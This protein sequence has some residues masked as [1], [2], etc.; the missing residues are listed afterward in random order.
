MQGNILRVFANFRS[1]G[2]ANIRLKQP[3]VDITI[4]K[5][6]ESALTGF[7]DTLYLIHT[8]P[9]E[10]TFLPSVGAVTM[11]TSSSKVVMHDFL[12]RTMFDMQ[13]LNSVYLSQA[14]IIFCF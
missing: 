11:D 12:P 10:I 2:K 9:R 4:S 13:D 7:L 3:P 8:K 6:E 14:S 1:E 5:A